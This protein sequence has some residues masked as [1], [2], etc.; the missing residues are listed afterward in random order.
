LGEGD[1][2]AT[3]LYFPGGSVM[4]VLTLIESGAAVE[5]GHCDL[6]TSIDG[7]PAITTSRKFKSFIR[8]RLFCEPRG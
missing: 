2:P 3:D 6:P 8:Q 1:K 7:K 5:V 4:Q